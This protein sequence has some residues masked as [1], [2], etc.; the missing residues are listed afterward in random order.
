MGSSNWRGNQWYQYKL[1]TETKNVYPFPTIRHKR[2]WRTLIQRS[3]GRYDSTMGMYQYQK[4]PNLRMLEG[5]KGI[6]PKLDILLPSVDGG[7]C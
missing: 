1:K 2:G 3:M 5:T 7:T 4:G 6:Q